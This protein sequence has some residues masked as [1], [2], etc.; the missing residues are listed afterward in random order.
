MAGRAAAARNGRCRRPAERL[1]RVGLTRLLRA[2]TSAQQVADTDWPVTTGN[3]ASQRYAPLDQIDRGN[4]AELEVAW[5]WSSPDNA[6]MAGQGGPGG[7]RMTPR[8]HE[9]IPIKVGDRLY[10]TTGYGQIAAVDVEQGTSLWTYDPQA[11]L[12][13]RPANLGFVHRGATYW[14]DPDLPGDGGRLLWAGGDSFLRA[15]DTLSGEPI[16]SFCDGGGVDLTLGLRRE[17]A[18]RVYSVSSPVTLCR[19]VVIVG[20][21][22]AGS[23]GRSRVARRGDRQTRRR[24]RA[25]GAHGR[26]S[27]N[28][29]APRSPVP[30]VRARRA[31]RREVRV[32]RLPAASVTPQHPDE[33]QCPPIGSL[34]PLHHHPRETP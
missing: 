27:D 32:D 11:Y 23:S 19:D 5:R 14:D 29:P 24:D 7:P 20:S 16:E 28:V 18:R 10:V 2:T 26:Q 34:Q 15:V 30:G 13:G 6:L 25:A 4:F 9:A 33:R 12:Q 3:N 22:P 17:V 8:N 21:P 31:R 1:A